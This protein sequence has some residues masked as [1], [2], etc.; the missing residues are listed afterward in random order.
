LLTEPARPLIEARGLTRDFESGPGGLRGRTRAVDGV[1]LDVGV[2]ET[3]GLVGESG[4]GKT[5]L[6]RLLIR[7]LEPTAGY[8]RFDG[9]DLATLDRGALRRKRREFQMVFQD[10]ASSLDPRRTVEE[11]LEEPYRIQEIGTAAERRRRIEELMQAVALDPALCRRDAASLSGGEQQRV[12]VAR[13]IALGPRLLIADE[14]VAALDPSIAA[15]VLNLLADL[16]QRF[17][18]TLIIVSHSLAVIRRLA[19]RMAVMSGGRIVEQ[20]RVD[21]FFR[22][23]RHPYS[24]TLL[25]SASFLYNAAHSPTYQSETTEE[26]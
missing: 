13:A 10:P 19:T 17:Q 4:S 5:T 7:L 15:Q 20:S 14:P 26:A 9:V 22:G 21:E 2:G 3:F 18:L 23:P 16:Q 6:G 25:R 1:D 11:V 12:V 24:K 8:V